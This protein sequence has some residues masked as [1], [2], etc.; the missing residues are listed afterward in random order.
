MEILVDRLHLDV[1]VPSWSQYISFILIGVIVVTN[2]RGLLIQLMKVRWSS[3]F[4]CVS[5]F[6]FFYLQFFRYF[7]SSV[8]SSS[9][10]LFLALVMGMYFVSSVLLMRM[11]LPPEYRMILSK[12]LGSLHFNFYHRWFDVLFLVSAVSS[13]LFLYI[14]NLL[15]T[16]SPKN[17]SF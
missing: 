12:V 10:V 9:T 15:W 5:F 16:A 13:A 7:A 8:S 6:Y 3:S 2:I 11:N 4:E 1:D 17:S 14:D